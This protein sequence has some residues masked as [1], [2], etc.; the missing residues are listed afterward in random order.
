MSPFSIV[1]RES[2][3]DNEEI[4]EEEKE[5]EDIN[6]DQCP[7]FSNYIYENLPEDIKKI[8]VVAKDNKERDI[9]LLG[10]ITVSS[11]MFPALRT[12]YGNRKY[13]AHIYTFIVAGAGAGKGGVMPTM[14]SP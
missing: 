5:E 12:I 10:I 2:D 8:L 7:Q 3:P 1:N 13:S 14:H 6:R 9:I 4:N 11:T